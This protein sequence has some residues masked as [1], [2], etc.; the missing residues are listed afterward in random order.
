MTPAP[1]R[2][3]LALVLALLWLCGL[4]LRVPILVAPALAPFIGDE[5]ALSQALLGALTTLPVFMLA[6]GALPGSLAIA[7]WGPR[8]TL[9]LALAV[10]ALASAARG[11][12]PDT[13]WLLFASA[14]MGLGIAAMQPALPALLPRWLQPHHIAIGAAVYMNGMLLGEFVGA[15]LTLPVVMPLVDNSW[16]MTLVLWSIP[17]LVLVAL[18]FLPIREQHRP[19]GRPA[20]LPDWKQPLTYKIGLLLGMSSALFFGTNAYLA[21]LLLE[22]GEG[23]YLGITLMLFNLAQGLASVLMLWTARYW[24]GR[25]PPLLWVIYLS[26]AGMLGLILFDGWLAIGFAIMM[27]FTSALQLILLVALPPLL[28]PSEDTGRLSAGNFTIGY[29]LSFIV[30]L[31]GGLVADWTGYTVHALWVILLY[32]LITLPVAWTLSLTADPPRSQA[33]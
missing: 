30:P 7:H 29:T 22:R 16:R 26:L 1:G 4:F 2:A 14:V 10:T 32:G 9:A 20:W 11:L 23:D 3:S 25:K 21:S 24:V 28:A 33:A 13:G 6:V 18:L 31:L 17:A 27:S 12:A 5:L 15:G 8:N 19:Q